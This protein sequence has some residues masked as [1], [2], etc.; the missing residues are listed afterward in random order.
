MTCC[1]PAAVAAGHTGA[2][3]GFSQ[4]LISGGTSASLAALAAGTL[5]GI[6]PPVTWPTP[7]GAQANSQNSFGND[8]ILGVIGALAAVTLVNTL[9]VATLERRRALRLLGRSG[10]TRG[11]VTAVFGWHAAFVIVTGLIAGAAAGAVALLVV[12]R[13]VTGSW[14]PYIPLAP[15]TGLVLAV[16]ALT[17]A[18][19]MVPV[20][21]MLHRSRP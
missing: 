14:T 6:W 18:A 12:T 13:A 9:A 1:I 19:V 4:I 11:Q 20:R 5:A 16:A 10:A 2:A 3:P 17:V 15:A 7:Q 21:L 8:L